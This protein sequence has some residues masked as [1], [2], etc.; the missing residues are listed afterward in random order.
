[1]SISGKGE[2]SLEYDIEPITFLKTYANRVHFPQSDAL[3][4]EA[5]IGNYTVCQI[6]V[7]NGRSVDIFYS[8]YLEKMG[9]KKSQLIMNLQPLYEFTKDSTILGG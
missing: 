2:K 1:M 6:L 7:D 4:I 8:N 5:V 9:I 3:V